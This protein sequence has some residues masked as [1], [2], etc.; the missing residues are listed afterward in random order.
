MIGNQ[1][2]DQRLPPAKADEPAERPGNAGAY[3]GMPRRPRRRPGASIGRHLK[4]R[5]FPVLSLE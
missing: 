2:V 4:P 1:L 3:Q 5:P